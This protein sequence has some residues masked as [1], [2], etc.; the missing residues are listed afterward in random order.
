MSRVSVLI[1]T[2]NEESNLAECIDSCAWSDD[3]VVFDSMSEDR[4]V[5]I[6]REKGARVI[7]RRFDN[8]AGQRNA[9]LTTV[10]YKHPWVL[11]VDADERVPPDLAAEIQSA[12]AAAGEHVAMY[13]MRR[14]D[15]FLGKWL[16]RSSGYPS[17]FGRL[18]RLGRIRVEREVNEEYI[19]DGRVEHLESHLHH[20]PFNRGIAY[21]FERHN[22]Y[23][24][25]E[26]ASKLGMHG[27][28]IV[29]RALF[30]GDPIDRRRTLKQLLYH[31]PFRPQIVFFYL[32]IVRLGIL[33]GRAGF[34][35]S[36]MRAT[37]EMLIDLKVVESRR[38][39][40][41]FPV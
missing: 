19:A 15:H 18:V 2:L 20:F 11:M 4:T 6:A 41:G 7:E 14:K 33:D 40:Q 30:N 29:L 24:T 10:E 9:A 1:L 27:Q 28:R 39:Q 8:Y 17:W 36:R 16:R 5:E 32:Y 26:A 12:V 38:R 37:Y 23:S 22:R 21:W 13:R 34:H 25:M 35:F 3:I 31:V